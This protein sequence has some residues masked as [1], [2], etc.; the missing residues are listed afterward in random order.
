MTYDF[1][2]LRDLRKRRNLTINALSKLCNVSYVALSKLE[3]NLGNPE[4][5]T[6]DR[7]SQVFGLATHNLLALARRQEPL[8]GSERKCRILG[9]A[10]AR[11]I[12]LDGLRLFVVRAPKGA[13]ATNRLS[14]ATTTSGVSS[15]MGTSR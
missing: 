15:L 10:E 2:V 11:Y 6:L 4:L 12:E 9:K 3:R 13:A 14:I 8:T 5:K 1:S 7:I